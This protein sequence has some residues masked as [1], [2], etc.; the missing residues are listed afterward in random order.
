MESLP[1]TDQLFPHIRIVMGMVIG[2]GI[3][4][5][6]MGIA[7]LVQHPNRA[8][9]SL[10]H[11]LWAVS[12][13]IELVFYWWWQFALF[14]VHEWNFALFLFVVGYAV[15]LFLMAALL[16][17]DSLAEYKGYEDFF[18]KR[19]KWFFALFGLT[20]VFD[21]IDSMVK[22]EAHF[23]RFGYEYYVQTPICVALSLFAMWNGSPRFH[24]ALVIVHLVYQASWILRLFYTFN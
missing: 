9:V 20:F 11:I 5:I 4:R 7:G 15:V 18:L 3:T 21:L 10:I 2:L 22:G 6:L 12:I 23:A 13:L 1:L 14:A 24:L 17:P 19:R 8:K 16:F